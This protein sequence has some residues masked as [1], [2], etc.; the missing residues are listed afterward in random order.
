MVLCQMCRRF[1]LV[2]LVHCCQLLMSF[3][4]M[5]LSYVSRG[6]LCHLV[7]YV[8]RHLICA[9]TLRKIRKGKGKCNFYVAKKPFFNLVGTHEA[10]RSPVELAADA[11]DFMQHICPEEFEQNCNPKFIVNMDQTPILFTCHSKKTLEWKGMKSVNICTSTNDTKRA[12]MAISE[13][14]DDSKLPPMLL[15][16]GS[17]CSWIAKEEFPNFP[18]GCKNYCQE[19]AW[20]D[21]RAMIEWV[22]IFSNLTLK[23]HQKMLFHCLCWIPPGAI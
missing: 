4:G 2:N 7:L 8:A 16:R 23:W 14:A 20:M 11:L 19:N 15:F 17:Q 22:E 18:P 12:T 1:T 21:E 9:V 3:F 10:Q 5:S 6:L 13:C